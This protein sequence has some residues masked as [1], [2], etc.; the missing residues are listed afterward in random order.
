MSCSNVMSCGYVQ[1]HFTMGLVFVSLQ[2]S[3]MNT[4][5]YPLQIPLVVVH[6]MVHC[7]GDL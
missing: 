5:L 3:T 1:M 2:G 7:V 4:H 6:G